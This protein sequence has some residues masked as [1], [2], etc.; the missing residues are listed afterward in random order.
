MTTSDVTK[1]TIGVFAHNSAESIEATLQS[2]VEQTLVNNDDNSIEAEILILANG[3]TDDTARLSQFILEKSQIGGERT[4]WRVIEID[5]PGKC[6]TWNLFVHDLSSA[7]TD[8]FIFMDSDIQFLQTDTLG[9]LVRDLQ[10]DEH[11]L[12]ST[13]LPVKDIAL[14]GPKNFRELVSLWV[15]GVSS[16]NANSICGQLYCGKADFIRNVWLPATLPVEDGF[17]RAM[18]I[19]NRFSEPQDTTRIIRSEDA[20]H[21]FEAHIGT[22]KLFQHE[23]WL[24]AASTINAYIYDL[25]WECG[26]NGEDVGDVIRDRNESDSKWLEKLIQQK[27]GK[28]KWWIVPKYFLYR[29]FYQLAKRSWLTALFKMPVAVAAFFFDVLICTRVNYNL[30]RN[31]FVRYW[32]TSGKKQA[33]RELTSLSR[34]QYTGSEQAR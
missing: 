4:S 9:N 32:R 7:D 10:I 20:S 15:S 3:C 31:M 33:S 18:V 14:N 24:V 13:D 16:V 28:K 22:K 1:V 11:A 5:Q 2:L 30:K 17:L 25:L 21:V 29:R 27:I 23:E 12:V 34:L 26:K 19:T 6:N 8:L